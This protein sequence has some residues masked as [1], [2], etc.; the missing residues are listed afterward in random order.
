MI[1]AE[2]QSAV[3]LGYS[4][5]ASMTEAVL[6]RGGGNGGVGERRT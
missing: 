6:E 4:S 5:S 2:R 1:T 3:V